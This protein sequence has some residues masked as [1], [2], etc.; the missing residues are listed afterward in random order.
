M[1][2]GWVEAIGRLSGLLLVLRSLL[3]ALVFFCS[4]ASSSPPFF[5]AF[6]TTLFLSSFVMDLRV[7]SLASVS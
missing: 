1:A 6:D 3:L 4:F 7:R 2:A 5:P